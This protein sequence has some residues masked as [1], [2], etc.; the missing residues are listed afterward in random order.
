VL[1]HPK[2]KKTP[3]KPSMSTTRIRKIREEEKRKHL[4]Q[5]NPQSGSFTK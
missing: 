1:S 4:D 5:P 2:N 3:T